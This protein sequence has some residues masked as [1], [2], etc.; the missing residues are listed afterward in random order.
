M[1]LHEDRL[2]RLSRLFVIYNTL[3]MGQRVNADD[4]AAACHCHRKTIQRD[5]PFLQEAGAQY[6][7]DAK[8]RSYVLE[9]PLPQLRVELTLPEILALALW[10]EALPLESGLP[11]GPQARSAFQKLAGHLPL[12]LRSELEALRPLLNVQGG[13]RHHYAPEQQAPLQGVIEAARSNHTIEMTYYT[14][15]RDEVS[16]R[17]VDPYALALQ[18]GYLNLVAYCH[19]RKSMRLFALDNI[20]AV[21]STDK[22]FQRQADFSL[23]EFLHGS[24]GMLRGEPIHIVV[25]FEPSIARWARRYRWSFHPTLEE[26]AD[27]SIVMRGEVSGLDGIRTELLRWG[28]PVTVLEP[29]ALRQALLKEAE[30]LVK[31]YQENL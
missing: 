27:G 31:K 30:A 4:L 26:Q 1:S 10:R 5:L 28:S 16:L 29:P 2:Q 21:H 8:Q 3:A 12:A 17:N 18:G 15:S 9:A 13:I 25:R 6:R 23:S 11:Y 14:I 24:L 22:C 7:W 20:R 19:Q